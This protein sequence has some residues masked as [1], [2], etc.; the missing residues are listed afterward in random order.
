[1]EAAHDVNI[2]S[3]ATAIVT[4]SEVVEFLLKEG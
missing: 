2:P 4:S 1:M 3:Y